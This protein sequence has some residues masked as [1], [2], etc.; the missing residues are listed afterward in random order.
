MKAAFDI[1]K[2]PIKLF[3]VNNGSVWTSFISK[4]TPI[5]NKPPQ[6]YLEGLWSWLTETLRFC[7][8]TAEL[9][10]FIAT[11]RRATAA[12][13]NVNS[14]ME[15]SLVLPLPDYEYLGAAVGSAHKRHL[16][17]QFPDPLCPKLYAR[18]N[19]A[20]QLFWLRENYLKESNS[21]TSTAI[22]SLAFSDSSCIRAD[23]TGKP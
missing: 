18:L 20:K 1:D 11:I 14:Q 16:R 13:V 2:T 17:S 5:K 15:G 4:K 22:L 23:I 12:P 19:V 3:F 6:A 8:I 10:G 9:T 7:I 21:A